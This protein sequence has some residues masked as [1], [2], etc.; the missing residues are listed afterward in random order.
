MN[1]DYKMCLGKKLHAFNSEECGKWSARLCSAIT[2]SSTRQ[3]KDHTDLDNLC[4]GRLMPFG[5]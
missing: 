4:K 2:N 5:K 3:M 1:K